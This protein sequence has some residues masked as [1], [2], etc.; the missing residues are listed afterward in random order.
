MLADK[1]HHFESIIE[2]LQLKNRSLEVELNSAINYRNMAEETTQY[3]QNN[4]D[5]EKRM[6]LYKLTQS[7]YHITELSSLIESLQEDNLNLIDDI[8]RLEIIIDESQKETES[9]SRSIVLKDKQ[10]GLLSH[11]YLNSTQL[12]SKLDE[13]AIVF[14]KK[15]PNWTT[16]KDQVESMV[17]HAQIW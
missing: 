2:A 17:I 9:I 4:L 1:S 15:F 13:V 5:Q 14:R 7:Q 6:F 3:C 11:Y 10:I 8:K 16:K 12:N